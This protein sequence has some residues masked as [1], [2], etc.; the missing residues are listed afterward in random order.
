[1]GAKFRERYHEIEAEGMKQRTESRKA[2][3][4][5][6]S[7]VLAER[8]CA[9]LEAGVVPEAMFIFIKSPSEVS[10]VQVLGGF[11]KY[12]SGFKPFA[13]LPLR[14]VQIVHLKE[15]VADDANL[16]TWSRKPDSFVVCRCAQQLLAPFEPVASSVIVKP[17]GLAFFG[18]NPDTVEAVREYAATAGTYWNTVVNP[19]KK[20][21]A[22][23]A[24]PPPP[25]PG[26][27]NRCRG[28]WL[29]DDR[30]ERGGERGVLL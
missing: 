10:L 30:Y 20:D 26:P 16:L 7:K 28:P 18:V 24:P 29:V 22:A 4:K 2:R 3:W 25:P 14:E 8:R 21:T 11:Q 17:G 1:V 15:F 19:P 13:S 6:Q 27:P 12:Q 5:S 9:N 23:A